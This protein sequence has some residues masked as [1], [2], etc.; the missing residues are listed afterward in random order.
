MTIKKKPVILMADD[1]EDD[2]VLV[3]DAFLKNGLKGE[4]LFV[5]DGQELIDYLQTCVN[6]DSVPCPDLILL[7]LNMPK[8]DG[9]T[10]LKEIKS[11]PRLKHIPVIIMTTSNEASDVAKC[12]RNGA[13]TYISK[14]PSF[15][16]LTQ[17]V[18]CINQYWFNT[19]VLP[20]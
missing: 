17:V 13:S 8:K 14:P 1:D 2:R 20:K 3:R 16:Q 15:E 11:D 12:Y 7:D 18:D 4:L 19:A 10:A 9:R 5:E 6:N